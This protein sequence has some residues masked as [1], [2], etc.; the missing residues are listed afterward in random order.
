[1]KDKKLEKDET[2]IFRGERIAACLCAALMAIVMVS[3]FLSAGEGRGWYVL[4]LAILGLTL[5][6][7]LKKYTLPPALQ[8]LLAAAVPAL[9]FML[10]E[11]TTHLLS[12]M[13]PDPVKLNLVYYYLIFMVFV[14]VTGSL[15]W[16]LRIPSFLILLFGTANYFVILFRSIPIFPWDIY[17]LGVASSVAADYDYTISVKLCQVLMLY[18]LMFV[19]M[20]R[21]T[22]RPGRGHLKLRLSGL[23]VSAGLLAAFIAFVQSETLYDYFT[24]D[25]TLFTPKV[26]YRNNGLML[27]FTMDMKYLYID[28]PEGYS[29]E[30]AAAITAGQ[31]TSGDDGEAGSGTSDTASGV[32]PHLIV[33]MNEAFSDLSVLGDFETDEEVMPFISSLTENTRKGWMFSSVKGGNTANTEF[34]FLTGM[35][36]C[37]LPAGSVPY[38]QYIRTEIPSLASQLDSLDYTS[39]SLHPYNASGWNRDTVYDDFGFEEQYFLPSFYGAERIR[40]YVSD[41]ATYQKIIDRYESREEGEILFFF[42]VTMQNHSGY[43]KTYDDFVNEVHV[44]GGSGYYLNATEQYLTLIRKSDEAFEELVDYFSA[45]EEP[46]I[47]LMFGDHQPNDYVVE[48]VNEEAEDTLESAQKR[49][50]VPYVL[51]ANYDIEEAEGDITSANYLGADLLETAGLPLTEFQSWL[52]ALSEQLPVVTQ[53]VVID[54]EGVYHSC[55]DPALSDILRDYEILQYNDLFDSENRAQNCFY[56]Q[57]SLD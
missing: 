32:K 11:N 40:T 15:K 22:I 3:S 54:A 20:G 17:S 47:I 43:T 36:M 5:F 2:K 24:I 21:L 13:W 8:W 29:P 38:Q 9:T 37:F 4:S 44:A 14:L 51:W 19:L 35:S 12:E 50:M 1:M 18:G 39:V 10:T 30:T 34:E 52:E 26:F 27:S 25:Q 7:G 6:L 53:N 16:G 57:N 33:V 46:V 23:A 42:D 41:R 49:Y 48:S 56:L 28:E 55:D 45:Q 31:E